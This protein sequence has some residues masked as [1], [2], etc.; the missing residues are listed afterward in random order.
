MYI[1]RVELEGFK[2][3]ARKTTVNLG[4][5]ISGVVGPNGCG[6]SNIVDAIKWCLGEQSAKALRGQHMGDV[7]FN[8]S[9]TEKP[10]D[11]VEVSLVFNRGE[12]QFKGV[13]EGL[14]EVQ[15]TRRLTRNGQSAYML[16]RS[17]VRLKDVQL[18]FMDTGLYNQR[19]A[20]IEQ[21]QIG[22]IIE[23]RPAQ[24]RLLFEEAAGI[25]HFNERRVA[26][27][28][29]LK[30]T[31][32]NLDKVQ[33]V[34]DGLKKQLTSLERQAKKAVQ[35]QRTNSVIR[36]LS[37]AIGVSEYL[38]WSDERSA[39]SGQEKDILA[40]EDELEHVNRRQWSMWTQAK[41]SL[42]AKQDQ[43]NQLQKQ[44]QSL[45]QQ[46][47]KQQTTLSFQRKEVT[48]FEQRIVEVQKEL[49]TTVAEYSTVEGSQSTLND[50]VQIAEG[51][52]QEASRQRSSAIDAH[53]SATKSVSATDREIEEYKSNMDHA[54]GRV[55]K[56]EGELVAIHQRL[57]DIQTD[58][59]D[60]ESEKRA[61]NERLQLLL[62]E[63]SQVDKERIDLED[64]LQQQRTSEKAK[65]S[66]LS[67]ATSSLSV[68][69]QASRKAKD[70]Q[71]SA[72]RSVEKSKMLIQSTKRMIEGN[73][74]VSSNS[75]T[76]LQQPHVKGLLLSMLVV[77][78]EKEHLLLTL[79][80]EDAELIVL[81]P[82]ADRHKL[83]TL[84]KGRQRL[85]H[86]ST[87][88]K[89][90]WNEM[91]PMIEAWLGPL[92]D[93]T[94]PDFAMYTLC[95][96]LG[97]HGGAEGQNYW[98]S[99][100]VS[101]MAA[102]RN[103]VFVVGVPASVASE[104]LNRRRTL[105]SEQKRLVEFEQVH[106]KAN[107]ALAKARDAVAL[108]RQERALLQAALQD[109]Q[110]E[111][112]RTSEELM[113][114]KRLLQNLN[115]DVSA[116]EIQVKTVEKR[117]EAYALERSQ[118]EHKRLELQQEVKT[119][120]SSIAAFDKELRFSQ[121]QRVQQL[122]HAGE[123]SKRRNELDKQCTLLGERLI[124]TKQ[125]RDALAASITAL[126][127]RKLSYENE[128]L[129]IKKQH[130]ELVNSNRKLADSVLELEG[131]QIAIQSEVDATIASVKQFMEYADKME[132]S[133]QETQKE[134]DAVTLK[135]V[136]VQKEL[137]AV[138][139]KLT[140]LK[141][142]I[143]KKFEIR[144]AGLVD[145]LN[146]DRQLVFQ[147]LDGVDTLPPQNEVEAA[148]VRPMYCSYV[149]LQSLEQRSEWRQQKMDLDQKL[150][151]FGHINFAAVEEIAGVESE[152][153]SMMV[154][155]LDLENSIQQIDATIQQLDALCTE[156]FLETVHQVSGYFQAL[157]PRL[158]GGGSSSIKML[159][160][161]DP[162][163]TG[164]SIFAQPPGKKL[165]RLSLL[166]GGERAMVAIALLFSLFQV[167]PSP[168]CLMDEVDA[169][170]D[171]ANGERFNTML[172]EMSTNS[173]FIVITHNKKT[174]E[175]V[176]TVYGVT[177]PTPGVSQLVS[178][179][180]Q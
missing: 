158:V 47:T 150:G 152:H 162:L 173:Q 51:R 112:R 171:E 179:K 40:K 102:M 170:L 146:I 111:I 71:Q 35:Y 72:Q 44:L 161:N 29:K 52:M 62:I 92:H 129:S 1:D 117:A 86:M 134:K 157:Y 133:V 176:D 79:L 88:W 56:I 60:R 137:D 159:E 74:G 167:K 94:G 125:R 28:G 108:K 95:S 124:Q 105:V 24:M 110:S 115:N 155:K 87:D 100:S 109:L 128:I 78:K 107:Q 5:G 154:Q 99:V 127:K 42:S 160:P 9:A 34:V 69:E 2:S 175:V 119:L 153:D 4:P 39:L 85:F 116:L 163:N 145:R 48:V 90:Q 15:V 98:R 104:L 172:K 122:K 67:E 3:F 169:P 142:D 65:K 61:V 174:M 57:K 14:E 25:S 156:R 97:P 114:R 70:Q 32:E 130:T 43:S 91:S 26:T 121:E 76:I 55:S 11:F 149:E 164:I 68:L 6:K 31:Q 64:K 140:L 23:A 81:E 58:V 113:R 136:A 53:I 46:H 77:P 89:Q 166:S 50:E 101:P 144:L 135:R 20:L 168:V 139:S 96:L 138:H 21:G 63:Q 106:E 27:Q 54:R 10:A 132:V 66:T 41:Q 141:H 7:I 177:M 18:F 75:K 165:E 118:K 38:E 30:S 22:Q 103:G 123:C 131:Q 49:A 37:L 148:M 12:S 126:K 82:S 8:G 83:L 120:H 147:P 180:F 73:Q 93:I 45:T 33:I 13:F 84:A 80:G 59:D 16:N 19:Y 178:V 143:L 151:K 17:K 36:Q